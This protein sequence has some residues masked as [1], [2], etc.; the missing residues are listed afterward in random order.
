MPTDLTLHGFERHYL[1]RQEWCDVLCETLAGGRIVP[2]GS[3]HVAQVEQTLAASLGRRHAIGVAS[4]S[5]ALALVMRSL[6]LPSGAEVI[7]P[8]LT[9][10]A[11]A[12]GPVRAGCEVRF[13]D[14]HPVSLQIDVKA[15]EAALTS[16]TGAVVAVHLFGNP[17]PMEELTALCARRGIPVIE[18]CAQAI[19]ASLSGR[20]I[21]AWGFAGCFSCGPT[22]PWTAL[23]EGGFVVLDDDEVATRVRSERH[24]GSLGGF[25]HDHLG[26]NAMMDSLQA[27]LLL[28][29]FRKLPGELD[30]LR[31]LARQYARLL[32]GCE[33]VRVV[34]PPRWETA[35]PSK[36]SVM[37]DV[38]IDRNHV[39]R[40]LAEVGVPTA[41]YYPE[42]LHTQPCFARWRREERLPVAE[43]AA[44]RVLSLP[45][46]AG[47]T[48]ADVGRVV[49]AMREAMPNAA[50]RS[51]AES[52]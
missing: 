41:V 13:V 50:D 4:G 48:D 44:T 25:H 37:L 51:A 14:V 31:E 52:S 2:V 24:N 7:V 27:A 18:D 30:I 40:R 26:E 10:Q 3:P 35:C 32:R 1:E 11:S 49:A 21:G 23:G 45:I 22:K 43:D 38:G 9:F 33:G 5:A 34:T 36:L 46:H 12:A 28:M 8:T 6:G 29:R 20:R 39:V 19:G 15:V 47:R 16:R 42:P 17:A